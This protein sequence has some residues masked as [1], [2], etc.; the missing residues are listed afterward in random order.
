MAN[1][2]TCPKCAKQLGL[3]AT[4]AAT[5]R[6]ECPECRAIFSLS[7]TVQISLPV[8]R[9][10]DPSEQ[11]ATSPA[12]DD[13]LPKLSE[14]AADTLADTAAPTKSW[15]ERLKNALALDSSED[16]TESIAPKDDEVAAP[17][18]EKATPSK[19]PSFEFELEPAPAVV[20]KTKATE[21]KS[22]E[23]K[24]TT[25]K[26][27][28]LGFESPGF[29]PHSPQKVSPNSI[30]ERASSP[31]KTLAE[32]ATG[33]LASA[34]EDTTSPAEALLNPELLK[35]GLPKQTDLV[36]TKNS[37]VTVA[38]APVRRATRSRLPKVAALL[39]AGP[40]IGSLLGLY[41]LLWVQGEQ[42]DFF[43]LA[44]MLPATLLPDDFGKSD[45]NGEQ[46]AARL[47]AAT[48]PDMPEQA[49]EPLTAPLEVKRDVAVQPALATGL[50]SSLRSTVRI[51]ASRFDALVEAAEVALPEFVAGDLSESESIKRKGQAY[52]ALCR[53][54]EHFDFAQQAALAPAARAKAHRA[55]RLFQRIAN[56]AD[57]RQ[58]LA[59]I[60]GRWWEYDQRPSPGIFLAGK[61]RRVEPAGADSIGWVKMGEQSTVPAI[62]VWFRR[63][64]YQSGDHIGVV[65]SVISSPSDL[66]PDFSGGQVV[67]VAYSFEL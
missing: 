23:S 11:P 1:I 42:A 22:P 40:V 19:T 5:D 30:A 31:T 55:S 61:V 24:V 67:A 56:Q 50:V 12:T 17:M 58:D 51:D 2:A 65:G 54:A 14:S 47:A 27:A 29:P 13:V 21:S 64:R 6:A 9:V 25:P 60:A 62:P 15:E 41:G 39:V 18:A 53:L 32:F 59:Q 28:T 57:V 7:E 43:G 45:G 3:P 35:S 8:A 38:I 63:E 20:A 46:G 37:E 48:T 4:I 34:G 44:R 36:A 26:Q 16:Q 33:N 10:L 52:M 49:T 66:P